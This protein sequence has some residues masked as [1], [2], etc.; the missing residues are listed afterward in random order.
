MSTG[1]SYCMVNV[2]H[3]LCSSC[4]QGVD[5]WHSCQQFQILY[6]VYMCTYLYYV[7]V[8]VYLAFQ[9]CWRIIAVC[10]NSH[11][12]CVCAC[13]IPGEVDN[14]DPTLRKEYVLNNPLF[15]DGTFLYMATKV[16][17]WSFMLSSIICVCGIHLNPV[18]PT[19]ID[20]FTLPQD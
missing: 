9:I 20:S 13:V 6:T 2:Y 19:Y 12:V 8:C 3:G 7:C 1:L 11:L 10:W 15:E 17:W 14:T 16:W 18:P 5:C 4:W